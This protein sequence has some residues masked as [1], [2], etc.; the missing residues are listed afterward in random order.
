M[1]VLQKNL[2]EVGF[3]SQKRRNQPSEHTYQRHIVCMKEKQEN[4]MAENLLMQ[5]IQ[6][7]SKRNTATDCTHTHVLCCCVSHTV[8]LWV[9]AVCL[10]LSFPLSFSLS[11]SLSLFRFL[12]LTIFT[13]VSEILTDIFI[14]VHRYTHI[15]LSLT[16]SAFLLLAQTIYMH[17][18]SSLGSVITR[19]LTYIFTTNT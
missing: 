13:Y 4:M 19:S 6:S 5:N 15:W 8:S 1:L 10:S 3:F 14:Y 11:L 12:S 17:F 16:P 9:C 2:T 7:D 18:S